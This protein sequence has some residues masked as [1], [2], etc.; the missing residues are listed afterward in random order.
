MIDSDR[1][2]PP[3]EREPSLW[4][5]VLF[6]CLASGLLLF[7][8]LQ[9]AAHGWLPQRLIATI[10]GDAGIPATTDP[11][12]TASGAIPVAGV[13]CAFVAGNPG[14]VC[15]FQFED[16][17]GDLVWPSLPV[18]VPRAWLHAQAATGPVA[19]PAFL[20]ALVGSPYAPASTMELEGLPISVA[21]SFGTQLSAAGITPSAFLGWLY[22]H[23]PDEHRPPWA[24]G[25]VM[26]GANSDY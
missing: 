19:G 4:R 17:R 20:A 7:G 22:Q 18:P 23:V 26:P 13:Q 11:E 12:T 9:A 15:Q 10:E 3:Q 8:I 6:A 1:A 25:G 2:S 24:P 14:A 16:E 5:L 21:P